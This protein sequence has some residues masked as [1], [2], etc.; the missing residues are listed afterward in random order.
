[1]AASVVRV[2]LAGVGSFFASFSCA[3]AS[4]KQEKI[5][6]KLMN[7]KSDLLIIISRTAFAVAKEHLK[8]PHEVFQI[9]F[10]HKGECAGNLT[11]VGVRTLLIWV[12]AEQ[13][14]EFTQHNLDL[15]GLGSGGLVG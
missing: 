11:N 7:P 14:M 5:A 1:M 10:P 4:W 9:V 15:S 13:R 3:F 6:H 2:F 12:A 8:H